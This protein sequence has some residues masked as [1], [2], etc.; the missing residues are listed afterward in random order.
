MNTGNLKS[1]ILFDGVC[2]LCNGFV[3]FIIKHDSKERFVFS[4]LQS[5]KGKE[6]LSRYNLPIKNISTVVLVEN[7]KVFLQS[8]AVLRIAR[9][10]NGGWKLFYFFRIFPKFIRD[11]AYSMVS[12]YRYRIFGKKDE[13]MVPTAELKTRFLT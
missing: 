6:I 5:D 13:C 12:K 3:R 7:G 2:N 1:I 8:S 9:R 10:L 11:F 4:A